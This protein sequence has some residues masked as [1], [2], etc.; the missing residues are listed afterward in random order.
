MDSTINYKKL[1]EKVVLEKDN[2]AIHIDD[3]KSDYEK[4][5]KE[6]EEKINNLSE[7]LKK[8]TSHKGSKKYYEK[9]KEKIIETV[10]AYNKTH[11]RVID[12]EKVKEYNK[13]AYEKRKQKLLDQNPGE[14][15]I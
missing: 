14:K 6:L 5:I 3:I 11:K 7:H 10:K 1:Y 13:R 8:Y 4:K 15:N 12:P 2:L 9:N